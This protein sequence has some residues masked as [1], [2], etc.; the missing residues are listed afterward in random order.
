MAYRNLPLFPAYI[1]CRDAM[2]RAF[3]TKLARRNYLSNDHLSPWVEYRQYIID[4]K[5]Q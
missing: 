4:F 3:K 2:F 5:N 1:L